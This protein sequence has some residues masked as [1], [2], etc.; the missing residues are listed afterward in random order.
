[1][2]LDDSVKY[3]H[4][5]AQIQFITNIVSCRE[6]GRAFG[7]V[8]GSEGPQA[9]DPHVNDGLVGNTIRYMQRES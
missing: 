4:E 6:I 8:F 2:E 3:K 1:M 7:I 5:I 9:L